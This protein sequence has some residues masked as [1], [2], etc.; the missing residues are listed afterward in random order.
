ME[1]GREYTIKACSCTKC[2]HYLIIY[3]QY[4]HFYTNQLKRHDLDIFIHVIVLQKLT[5]FI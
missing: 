4:L 2:L 3:L 5:A 1:F